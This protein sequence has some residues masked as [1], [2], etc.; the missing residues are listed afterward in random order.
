MNRP[1]TNVLAT[2]V[3]LAAAVLLYLTAALLTV[4]P[5]RHQLRPLYEGI[6]PS[7]PYR[8][9]NPPPAFKSTN[10][11]PVPVS[12]SIDL[13]SSGS[14]EEPAGSGDG[15]LAMTLPAGAIPPSP[16]RTSVVI[17]V[18]PVDPAKLAPLPPGLYSNGNAY[19]V[20]ADYA[21]GNVSIPASA[22]PVDAVLRTPVSSVA[23]LASPDGK[24][25][26]RI[27]DQHIPNQ[28]AVATTF[29]TFGYLLA[30]ANVPVVPKSS[31]S[32]A[33]IVLVVGLGI[34]AVL[35]LAAALIWRS[36]RRRRSG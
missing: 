10:I 18:T 7:A 28:A 29:T 3:G 30:A 11:P 36:D 8:W 21:P 13:T 20:T 31:S 6:G 35:L 15:Q 16:G 2:T 1:R 22:Q 19:R 24:S 26:A 12:E 32:G 4:G 33:G 9:V 23:L 27:P 5:E 34:A 14:P 25:W 17:S